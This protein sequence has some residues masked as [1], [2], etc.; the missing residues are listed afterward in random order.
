MKNTVRI[1]ELKILSRDNNDKVTKFAVKYFGKKKTF[2]VE[3]KSQ[4]TADLLFFALCS[5]VITN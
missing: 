3:N 1:Q 2:I 4:E 5:H